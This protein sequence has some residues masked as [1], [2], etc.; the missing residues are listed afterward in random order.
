VIQGIKMVLSGIKIG[1]EQ[2]NILAYVDDIVLIGINETEIRQIFVETENIAGKFG[3]QKNQGNT[4][5]MTVER[6]NCLKQN[7][8]GQLII[9]NYTFERAENFKCLCVILNADYNHQIDLQGRIKHANKTYFMPQIK[10]E[11]HNNRQTVN[12]C[13]RNLDTNKQKQKG[14]KHFS[15]ESVQKNFRPSIWQ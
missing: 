2:L 13:I 14:N 6:K 7:K 11:E 8:I 4:K 9:K 1:K 12:M 10:T 15:K 5:Y 3:L